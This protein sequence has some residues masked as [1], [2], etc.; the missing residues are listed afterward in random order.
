MEQLILGLSGPPR[1]GKDTLANIICELLVGTA[2]RRASAPLKNIALLFVPL[3]QRKDIESKKD[4]PLNHL[5][6]TYRDLQI[7]AWILGR[8]LM[9]E[10]W[11]GHH[12][13]DAIRYCHAPLILVPDFGR[14]SEAAVLLHAE[15]KV[16][17]I[18]IVRPG[19]SF[20]GDSR[21]DF[22]IPGPSNSI[23]FYN[24]GTLM[25]L[26][27]NVIEELMPWISEQQR[28]RRRQEASPEAHSS[29]D[30]PHAA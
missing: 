7:G 25:E 26:R 10:D 28:P 5:G 6:T 16:R 24:S 18:K 20:E 3:L 29:S 17:Q 19:T 14:S 8:D 15:L 9:E 1:A 27:R 11:L 22:T 4:E 30:P 21:E 2:V 12:L 23:T 13:V